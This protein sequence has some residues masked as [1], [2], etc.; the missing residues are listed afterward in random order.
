MSFHHERVFFL[1][2][3]ITILVVP[4]SESCVT[5]QTVQPYRSLSLDGTECCPSN[6]V[7]DIITGIRAELTS[8]KRDIKSYRA[9]L[10][11]TAVPTS[12]SCHIA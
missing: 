4:S 5:C 10:Y 11:Q 12:A 6:A 9:L 8:E 7:V 3:C 2:V 1:L